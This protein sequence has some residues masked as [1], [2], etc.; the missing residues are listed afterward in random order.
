MSERELPVERLPR[1]VRELLEFL[2]E[3]YPGYALFANLPGHLQDAVT[4]CLGGEPQRNWVSV[5]SV[6]FDMPALPARTEGEAEARVDWVPCVPAPP[7]VLLTSD[8]YARLLVDRLYDQPASEGSSSGDQAKAP[9]IALTP[10][11][12]TILEALA[13]EGSMTVTQESLAAQTRLSDKTVRK[14]LSSLRT[15][16]LVHQPRGPKKGFG[17]TPAGLAAIGRK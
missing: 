16:G 14:Y 12:K 5:R 8:G 3:V 13:N 4:W 6:A 9:A 10:E 7:Q 1:R 2:A 11:E 17:I 15:H